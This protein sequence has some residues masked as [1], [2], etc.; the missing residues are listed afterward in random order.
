MEF[1]YDFELLGGNYVILLGG[2]QVF[3]YS[4]C[5]GE[6]GYAGCYKVIIFLFDVYVSEFFLA[7]F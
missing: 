1:R 3:W 7:K 5:Y 6:S 4:E 2:G